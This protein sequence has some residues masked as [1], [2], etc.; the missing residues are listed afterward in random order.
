MREFRSPCEVKQTT[1]GE[2]FLLSPRPPRC[3]ADCPEGHALHTRKRCRGAA[4]WR[5]RAR[6]WADT[7]ARVPVTVSLRASCL[8]APLSFA[9]TSRELEGGGGVA[10]PEL[11]VLRAGTMN[12]RPPES[13]LSSWEHRTMV[14]R[15]VSLRR[16]T[17]LAAREDGWG[18]QGLRAVRGGLVGPPVKRKR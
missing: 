11:P 3:W 8:M 1:R 2:G 13:R 14:R 7:R 15:H 12:P 6:R 16:A 18:A 17:Q 10:P 4:S 5:A 9:R